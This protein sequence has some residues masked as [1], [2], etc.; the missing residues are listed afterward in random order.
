MPQYKVLIKKPQHTD[1]LSLQEVNVVKDLP[2][3][4]SQVIKPVLNDAL[5]LLNKT[6]NTKQEKKKKTYILI[7]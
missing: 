6:T 1:W 2:L 7:H 5:T 4:G 3:L